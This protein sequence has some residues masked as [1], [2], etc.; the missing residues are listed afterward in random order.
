[1]RMWLERLPSLLERFP[2][3]CVRSYQRRAQEPRL[4]PGYTFRDSGLV[5]IPVTNHG[6]TANRARKQRVTPPGRFPLPAVI[7][8]RAFPKVASRAGGEAKFGW[9]LLL[10]SALVFSFACGSGHSGSSNGT[11]NSTPTSTSG[12]TQTNTQSGTPGGTGTA[13]SP[14]SSTG[15]TATTAYSFV[16]VLV[17]ENTSFSQVIGDTTDAPFL[18]SLISYQGSNPSAPGALA[19]NYFA[20]VH[21]SIGNY[22]M[23]TTGQLVT[24]DDTFNNTSPGYPVTVDNVVRELTA[25]GKSWKVYAE[26]LPAVGYTGGDVVPYLERHNPLS[27]FSDVVSSPQQSANIVPFTQFATDLSAGPAGSLGNLPNYA[28]IVP[29]SWDDSHSCDPTEATCTA[30]RIGDTDL[31]IQTNVGPLLSI[32]A[33]QQNGLLIITW[34]EAAT[35]DTSNGLG[36]IGGGQVATVLLGARVRP[37]YQQQTANVYDHSSLL[38]LTMDSLGLQTQLPISNVTPMTEFFQ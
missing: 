1:M 14:P 38:R 33:F 28:F 23:M 35:T 26:S 5:A 24:T 29:N 7:A 11:A 36:G 2:R 19:T 9:T 4:L 18:N 22:F 16:A 15:S 37:A 34:D 8:P 21:P 6:Q 25:A 13:G 30:E 32:P 3:W 31:W 27:Y 12:G 20:D 17:L 10:I